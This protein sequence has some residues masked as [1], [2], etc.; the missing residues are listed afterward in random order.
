MEMLQQ[1]S[2]AKLKLRM[3]DTK[4][5]TFV[6]PKLRGSISSLVFH[7]NA[8]FSPENNLTSLDKHPNKNN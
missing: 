2:K 8:W 5:N 4:S 7:E 3:K 1:E 6:N